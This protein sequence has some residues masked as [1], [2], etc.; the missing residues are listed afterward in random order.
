LYQTTFLDPLRAQNLSP[1]TAATCRE[2]LVQLADFLAETGMPVVPA[3]VRPED[4]RAFI[5]RLIETRSSSTAHNRCRALNR[6]FNWLVE[7]EY[8]DRSP[9]AK[10]KP[11]KVEE[12]GLFPSSAARTRNGCSAASTR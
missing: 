11:P 8:L 2:A 12:K 7:Q 6:F 3:E 5:T 4:T 9:M 10:L 1:N